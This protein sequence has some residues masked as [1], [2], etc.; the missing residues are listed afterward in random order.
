MSIIKEARDRRRES[1]KRA[2]DPA[3]T[4]QTVVPQYL[5]EARERYLDAPYRDL[6][7]M[8][9]GDPRIGFSALD[10]KRYGA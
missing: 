9:S 1:G 8:L 10:R 3:W 7:A 5:I 4:D 6:T 2:Y